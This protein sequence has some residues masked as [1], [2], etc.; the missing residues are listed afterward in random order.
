M[1][2]VSDKIYNQLTCPRCGKSIPV[3]IISLRGNLKISIKCRGC[4]CVSEVELE[5]I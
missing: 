2:A 5:D 3:R 1:S 4:K